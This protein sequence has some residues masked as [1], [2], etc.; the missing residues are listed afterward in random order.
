MLLADAK[1]VNLIVHI[2]GCRFYSVECLNL[3]CSTA[4]NFNFNNNNNPT[5]NSELALQVAGR[6][7]RFD[8]VKLTVSE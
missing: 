3:I 7:L 6:L 4:N 8:S 2:S 1:K 5:N